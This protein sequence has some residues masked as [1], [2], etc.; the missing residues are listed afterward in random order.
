MFF[1]AVFPLEQLKK[2]IHINTKKKKKNIEK[3]IF[4]ALDSLEMN[5][6]KLRFN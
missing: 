2:I 4:I 1:T 3:M 6:I 5:D